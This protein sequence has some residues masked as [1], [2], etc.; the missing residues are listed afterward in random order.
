MNVRD[1]AIDN[2]F[3]IHNVP[4]RLVNFFF[5]F[6]KFYFIFKLYINVL[7]LPN[8]KMNPPQVYNFK[9]K[10]L[11]FEAPFLEVVVTF[12]FREFISGLQHPDFRI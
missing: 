11:E 3:P 7:D 6:F 9:L 5:F 1:S 8:I 2:I 4:L 12:T 10:E